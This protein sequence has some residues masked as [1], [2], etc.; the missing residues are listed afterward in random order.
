MTLKRPN[1]F[2]YYDRKFYHIIDSAS[3]IRLRHEV[4]FNHNSP[5]GWK[6]RGAQERVG[7]GGGEG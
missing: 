6:G 2:I 1:I 7:G 5:E 3:N 4:L